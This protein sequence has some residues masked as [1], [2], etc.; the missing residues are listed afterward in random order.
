[1]FNEQYKS[2]V[3]SNFENDICCVAYILNLVAQDIISEYIKQVTS[4]EDNESGG[5]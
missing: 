5:K 1:M 4:E 2:I 3:G